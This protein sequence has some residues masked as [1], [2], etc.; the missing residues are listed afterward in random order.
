MTEVEALDDLGHEVRQIGQH[1][2][3]FL[4]NRRTDPR[5]YEPSPRQLEK[6]G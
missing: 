2:F 3:V 6:D 4:E 1:I 5:L